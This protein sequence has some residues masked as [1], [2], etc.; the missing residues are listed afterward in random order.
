[1]LNFIRYGNILIMGGCKSKV[2]NADLFLEDKKSNNLIN[3][4]QVESAMVYST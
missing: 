2:K 3:F 4:V 1:M